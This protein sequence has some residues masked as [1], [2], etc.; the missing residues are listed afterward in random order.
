MVD[1]KDI[2]EWTPIEKGKEVKIETSPIKGYKLVK[3]MLNGEDVTAN[4]FKIQQYGVL[5]A[6]FDIDNGIRNVE[7]EAVK[8]VQHNGNIVIMGLQPE[9]DY[10]IY[11]VLGKFLYTGMTDANGNA[12]ISLSTGHLIIIKQNDTVIKIRC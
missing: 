5:A 11:D 8:V 6:I 1:G 10:Q 7:T 9:K 12:E 2:P 4:T 3:I